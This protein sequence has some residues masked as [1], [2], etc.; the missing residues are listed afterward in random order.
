RR[1]RL[2]AIAL[3]GAGAYSGGIERLPGEIDYAPGAVRHEYGTRNAGLVAGLA[4]AVRLQEEIGRERIAAHGRE[5]A[6]QLRDGLTGVKDVTLLT[7]RP[8]GLRASITTFRHARA[9]AEKMFGY[10]IEQHRLR[11]RP[12]TE[13]GIE[14]TRIST[15]VFTSHADCERVIVGVRAAARVL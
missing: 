7:P 14:A 9:N 6:A 12:V 13:Q 4:E 3:T 1:P 8:D 15:H 11:C 10:L 2:E 5:L